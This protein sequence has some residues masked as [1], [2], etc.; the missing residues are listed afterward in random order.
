[1]TPSGHPQLYFPT[2]AKWCRSARFCSVVPLNYFWNVS[3][4]AHVAKASNLNH[5]L[6]NTSGA[7]A[8]PMLFVWTMTNPAKERVHSV[9]NPKPTSVFDLNMR[10][11][12]LVVKWIRDEGYIHIYILFGENINALIRLSPVLLQSVK[13]DSARRLRSSYYY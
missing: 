11:Y 3:G 5:L 12:P 9:G 4:L 10:V 2:D 1:M 7:T 13:R 6:P 8:C